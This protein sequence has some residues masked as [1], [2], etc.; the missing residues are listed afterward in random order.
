VY[1]FTLTATDSAAHLATKPL[2]ITILDPAPTPP[3]TTTVQSVTTT[4]VKWQLKATDV[5]PDATGGWTVQFYRNPGIV[6]GIVD[7]TSPHS[8]SAIVGAGTYRVT[9]VWTKAG[10]ATVTR[11]PVV[12]T[13]P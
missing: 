4:V 2:S 10:H 11:T 3:V 1:P 12:V 5:P 6:L 9:A 7:A 13:C 8:R